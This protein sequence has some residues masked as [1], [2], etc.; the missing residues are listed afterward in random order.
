M[1]EKCWINDII[2]P[3]LN[4]SFN[5]EKYRIKPDFALTYASEI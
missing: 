5:S 3:K 4:K 1:K 2:I